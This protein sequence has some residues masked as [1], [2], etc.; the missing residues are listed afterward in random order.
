MDS[1]T[2]WLWSLM[3]AAVVV[4]VVAVLLGMVIAAAKNI[5]RRAE[6]IWNVGKQ[7]T[8]NT[9]SVWILDVI[10]KRL[11]A[12]TSAAKKLDQSVSSLNESLRGAIGK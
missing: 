5:D 11:E 8:G 12:S 4:V 2:L 3:A 6:R 1:M 7:I 9:V 10:E